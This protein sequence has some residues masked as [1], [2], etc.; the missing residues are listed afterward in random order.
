MET[1]DSQIDSKILQLISEAVTRTKDET[2]FVTDDV[3]WNIRNVIKRCRK[4][5]YGIY[6]KPKDPVN[7]EDKIWVGLSEGHVNSV[8]KAIDLDLKDLLIRPRNDKSVGQARALKMVVDFYMNL[9]KFGELLDMIEFL[10]VRD[11]TCVIKA[12]TEIHPRLKKKAVNA[13]IVDLLN[14]FIDPTSDSIQDAAWVCERSLYPI[15][16]FKKNKAWKNTANVKGH[17]DQTSNLDLAKNRRETPFVEV[18][19]YWGK[20][21]AEF[22]KGKEG[23]WTDGHLVISNLFSEPKLHLAEENQFEDK[24]KPYEEARLERVD[25]RWHGRGVPEKLFALQYYINQIVNIRR[26]NSLIL[27]NGLFQIRKGSGITR[28]QISKLYAGGAIMVNR[29]NEDIAQLQVQDVRESS[30]KDEEQIVLWAQKIIGVGSPTGVG[31]TASTPA[32]TALIKQR[33][34][35]DIY[36][37]AQEQIGHF[38]ERLFEHHLIPLMKECL[39]TGDILRI[40]GDVDFLRE[41]DNAMLEIDAERDM[42]DFIQNFNRIPTDGEIEQAKEKARMKLNR[43]GTDR[44]MKVIKS[45]FDTDFDVS[46]RI[47][48]QSFDKTIMVQQLKELLLTV[49]KALPQTNLDVNAIVREILDM[50]GLQGNRFFSQNITQLG[51]PNAMDMRTEMSRT[52]TAPTAEDIFSRAQGA[53]ETAVPVQSSMR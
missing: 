44:F 13:K 39:N 26:N 29:I 28:D 30:Y 8:W 53:E 24:R 15:D 34:E 38:I 50:M 43:M 12:W 32:T 2:V 9:M 45:S 3:S 27:Q 42:S 21:P 47:T 7:G 11:G 17:T 31:L 48:D 22:V 37:F 33:A 10:T 49:S 14:F 40:T 4:N 1:K 5:Y 20:V 35:Q 52:Q 41:M 46:V 6:D 16:E 19:E 25:G 36:V 23:E 18:F 51:K